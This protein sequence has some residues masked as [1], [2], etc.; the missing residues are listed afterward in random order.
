MI[1]PRLAIKRSQSECLSLQGKIICPSPIKQ[2]SRL[3]LRLASEIFDMP[4]RLT[5]SDTQTGALSPMKPL[6]VRFCSAKIEN[7]STK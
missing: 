1:N 4:S 6:R 7:G 2:S 3:S 5:N